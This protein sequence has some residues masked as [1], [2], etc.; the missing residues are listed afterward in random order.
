MNMTGMWNYKPAR[1]HFNFKFST[2]FHTDKKADT[3]LFAEAEIAVNR[4]T[5]ETTAVTEK[6]LTASAN[7][8][9]D[10]WNFGGKMAY[11]MDGENKGM[12]LSQAQFSYECSDDIFSWMRADFKN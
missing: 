5:T 1:N 12:Q 8:V 11:L 9:G 4:D 10:K 6:T 7:V 2:Q 3:A